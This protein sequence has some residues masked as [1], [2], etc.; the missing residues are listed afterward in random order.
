MDL[1]AFAS[2]ENI[3]FGGSDGLPLKL[4]RIHTIIYYG[5]HQRSH[6]R[7]AIKR[8]FEQRFHQVHARDSTELKRKQHNTHPSPQS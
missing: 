1:G 7:D 4:L 3:R 2:T 5:Q 8:K 6:D